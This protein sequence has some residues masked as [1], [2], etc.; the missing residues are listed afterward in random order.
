[1][2]LTVYLAQSRKCQLDAPAAIIRSCL[3]IEVLD[4]FGF[5]QRIDIRPWKWVDRGKRPTIMPHTGGHH[6]HRYGPPSVHSEPNLDIKLVKSS[7]E[8]CPRD[9]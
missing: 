5:I 1:M 8:L 4:V 9:P 2:N 6:R 3:E 7:H